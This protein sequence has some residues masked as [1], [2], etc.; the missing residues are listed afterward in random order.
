[1]IVNSQ[2]NEL[3]TE[4]FVSSSFKNINYIIA[5]T[6]G[7][8]SSEIEKTISKI[9]DNLKWKNILEKDVRIMLKPNFTDVNYRPGVT[10]SPI[11]LRSI[12]KK[13][14]E[15]NEN[16]TI[17]EGN[18]GSYLFNADEAAKNHGVF[19]LVEE[20]GIKWINVSRLPTEKVHA[21]INKKKI[22][23]M[24][25]KNIHKIG[26]ILISIPVFKNHC[27]TKITLGIKNLWG[28]VP[29]EMRMLLHSKIDYYL[30]LIASY[31]NHKLTLI[32]GT[33]G[34]EGNGPMF[35]KPVEMKTLLGANDPVVA[36]VIGS[37]IMKND[38]KKISHIKSFADYR[39]Y[40]ID[41]I[42]NSLPENS[43]KFQTE[44]KVERTISNFLDLL[45][46][47][48]KTL[49]KIVFNSYLTPII[50]SLY[51]LINGDRTSIPPKKL[52]KK[53]EDR[54]KKFQ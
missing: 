15:W 2:N 37:W 45:T 47:K 5:K 3:E 1:M 4:S 22:K 25:P 40:C 19:D 48:N 46:F 16:I 33:I 44:L 42:L 18:G 23:L 8:S 12:V 9:I 27:M 31:Y 32:D 14:S 20:F 29:D 6:S 11:V 38:A 41:D 54:I 30:P 43:N 49:A 26:D 34:L 13:I 53:M 17:V 39:N 51:N 28:L 24:L 35:G 36:D 21:I 10:T 7:N 52:K 50:Y